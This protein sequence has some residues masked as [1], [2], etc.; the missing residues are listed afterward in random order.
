MTCYIHSESILHEKPHCCSN[1]RNDVLQEASTE[2]IR[3]FIPLL[4]CPEL[5]IK[6][7][8]EDNTKIILVIS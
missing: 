8:I 3:G 4:C 1:S 5:Q 7:G 6:G 2:Q